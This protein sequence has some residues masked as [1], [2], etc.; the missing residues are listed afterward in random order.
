MQEV[1]ASRQIGVVLASVESLSLP[2]LND[3]DVGQCL[4]GQ[5]TAEQ[6]D[7]FGHRN[8][9]G[10]NDVAV[11]FVRSTIPPYNGC[12]AHPAGRPSA[13]VAQGATQ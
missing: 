6:D 1:Y 8:N 11:Y 3:I 7:L 9:V 2:T 12:A 4:M 13:V 10:A 5:T